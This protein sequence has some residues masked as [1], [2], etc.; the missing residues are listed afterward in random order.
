MAI[1]AETVGTIE[2]EVTIGGG[3]VNIVADRINDQDDNTVVATEEAADDNTI[4]MSVGEQPGFSALINA[5]TLDAS[6]VRIDLP[7]NTEAG[8]GA[9]IFIRSGSPANSGFAA[10]DIAI[11]GG[12]GDDPSELRLTAGTTLGASA[13]ASPLKLQGGTS[14]AAGGAGGDVEVHGGNGALNGGRVSIQA[15]GTNAGA[16]PGANVDIESGNSPFTANIGAITFNSE[17]GFFPA[18]VAVET[19]WH[20]GPA[21]GAN[22][23]GF[24]AP[25]T[26]GGDQI[27]VLPAADGNNDDVQVTDGAGN[28]SYKA[29]AVAIAGATPPSVTGSR[30]G[31]AALASLL[32]VLAGLGLITDNSTA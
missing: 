27:F 29:P 8:D 7:S 14:F 17:H 18:S 3:S 20:E 32:T 11:V 30:G 9:E 21:N 25:D 13:K 10:G 6:A 15:G 22:Y 19:R 23:V 28:L 24:K 2:A 26:L 1:E 12:T 16:G 31:N 5:V 4:R